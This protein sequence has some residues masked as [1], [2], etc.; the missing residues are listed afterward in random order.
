M[1]CVFDTQENEAKR[2]VD[3]DGTNLM[4]N[5]VFVIWNWIWLE[6]EN[7]E[8]EDA[9]TRSV[10]SDIESNV[11][12]DVID[13]KEREELGETESRS[14]T[15][16]VVFKCIGASRDPNCQEVLAWASHQIR[17]GKH[18]EVRLQPEPTNMF[19]SL[20]IQF[21]LKM[22]DSWNR[23]GYVVREALDAVHNALK[24]DSISSVEVSWV[25]YLI[26]WSN[27][28]PGWYCG[29]KVAYCCCEV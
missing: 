4:S 21:V 24:S 16:S 23:I 5:N 25:K 14:I 1:L 10:E 17:E 26:H 15:H 12:K 8:D 9:T 19:D 22:N 20:A 7:D 28:G 2:A 6:P 18:V 27:S 13:D 3:L 29:I 11:N